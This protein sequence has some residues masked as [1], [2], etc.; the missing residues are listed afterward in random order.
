LPENR[1][2]SPSPLRILDSRLHADPSRVVLRPFHLGWQGKTS[3]GGRAQRLVE[4]ISSLSDREVAKAYKTVR[5]DFAARH[6]QTEQMFDERFAE[7]AQQLKLE[8]ED[9]SPARMRLIGA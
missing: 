7:V 3:A 8:P 1:N 9:Y 5:A 2:G 6:W 4:D